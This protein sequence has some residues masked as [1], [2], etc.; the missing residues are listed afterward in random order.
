M[1][2]EILYI[3]LLF[4]LFVVPRFVQRFGIPAAISSFALGAVAGM[5]FGL[6]VHDNT[7]HLLATFGIVSLFLFAGLEVDFD[8]L[9]RGSKVIVQHLVIRLLTLLLVM[10]LVSAVFGVASR[11]AA[12][13]GLA[14][15]TPS[16]GFILD[17]LP[18]FGLGEQE[19]FWVKSTAI[20]TELLALV[21]LFIVLRSASLT[22]LAVSGLGLLGIAVALPLV[23]RLFANGG[24]PVRAEVRIRVPPDAG[25]RRCLRNAPSGR[26]LPGRR[27]PRGHR[28]AAV[29]GSAAGDDLGKDAALDRS[30]RVVFR[31]VLLLQRGRPPSGQGLRI[32]RRADGPRLSGRRAPAEA[33]P[34]HA[35][36]AVCAREDATRS[37]RVAL[38]LLPTLVFTLVLA[39]ILRDQFDI[40]PNIFA[41]LIVFTVVNTLIPGLILRVP[42]ADPEVLHALESEEGDNRTRVPQVEGDGAAM[43]KRFITIDLGRRPHDDLRDRA[44]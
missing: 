25:H 14:L 24:G 33:R 18:A 43:Q 19:R 20:A 10:V 4:A 39:E 32:G 31:A 6:F 34:H 17:A 41:G 21:T 16:T 3:G 5:G 44:G 15:L 38:S 26:L 29:P 8:D 7:V 36:S 28:S 22:T 40:A 9:K 42:A 2:D 30:V 37:R 13:V 12:L 35:A 1:S 23:F 11:P 27:L